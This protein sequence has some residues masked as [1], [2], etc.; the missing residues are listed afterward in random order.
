[1]RD[2]DESRGSHRRHSRARNVE[3]GSA[4][5]RGF[6]FTPFGQNNERVR[7]HHKRIRDEFEV[8]TRSYRRR[9]TIDARLRPGERFGVLCRGVV[10]DWDFR[11]ETDGNNLVWFDQRRRGG[12]RGYVSDGDVADV[13]ETVRMRRR[14]EFARRQERVSAGRRRRGEVVVS[15]RERVTR[16]NR[17]G[18]RRVG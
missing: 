12:E 3:P 5:V 14:V 17:L 9:E 13:E 4:H 18:Y 10:R 16:G 8:Q 7:N 2:V 15:N 1:M 11:E 6:I